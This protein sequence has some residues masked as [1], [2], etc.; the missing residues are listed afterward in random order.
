MSHTETFSVA[1]DIVGWVDNDS[2]IMLKAVTKFGD[3]VELNAEQ[4][5]ELINAL[6]KCVAAI[7]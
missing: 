2:S 6:E 7:K 5:Q 3:P 1:E 4:A